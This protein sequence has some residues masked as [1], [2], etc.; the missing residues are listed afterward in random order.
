M[1]ITIFIS[2][3]VYVQQKW[4]IKKC[5]E[6]LSSIEYLLLHGMQK[7]IHQISVEMFSWIRINVYFLR[8]S[9]Q[10]EIKY[11]LIESKVGHI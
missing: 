8:G 4:L 3:T 9:K 1:K 2:P 11:Y 10:I 5:P 7:K 6:T